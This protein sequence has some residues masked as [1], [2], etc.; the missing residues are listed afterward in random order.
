M[1][2]RCYYRF[3]NQPVTRCDRKL[4]TNKKQSQ[5]ILFSRVEV[6][7]LEPSQL[8]QFSRND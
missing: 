8:G 7:D 4:V 1:A 3:L 2:A 5:N 6:A